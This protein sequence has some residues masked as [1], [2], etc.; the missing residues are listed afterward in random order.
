VS[1]EVIYYIPILEKIVQLVGSKIQ[2]Q[3][4]F[5]PTTL[6]LEFLHGAAMNLKNHMDT[7]FADERQNTIAGKSVLF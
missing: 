3:L 4:L 5:S 1:L 7:L 2:E 6:L